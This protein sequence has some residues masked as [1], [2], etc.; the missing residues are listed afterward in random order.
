MP[1]SLIANRTFEVMDKFVRLASRTSFGDECARLEAQAKARR[2]GMANAF[3]PRIRGRAG[4]DGFFYI[5]IH[6]IRRDGTY[7]TGYEHITHSD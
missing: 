3:V 1:K 5:R 7:L 4:A 6:K 2:L